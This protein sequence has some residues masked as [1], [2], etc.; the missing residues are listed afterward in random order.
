MRMLP[1]EGAVDAGG[2]VERIRGLERAR[3]MAEQG[4]IA[5]HPDYVG[6]EIE[7]RRE[8]VADIDARRKDPPGCRRGDCA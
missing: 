7:P 8:T 6:I 1:H 4:T 3:A 2:M 5:D